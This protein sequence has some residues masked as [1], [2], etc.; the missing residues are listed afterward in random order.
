M[1]FKAPGAGR[2][3]SPGGPPVNVQARA[4]CLSPCSPRGDR[5]ADYSRKSGACAITPIPTEAKDGWELVRGLHA[6]LVLNS[7][8]LSVC[9]PFMYPEFRVEAV[10]LRSLGGPCF[11]AELGIICD[12]LLGRINQSPLSGCQDPAWAVP[13]Y[14]LFISKCTR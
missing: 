3:V 6:G 13:A 4:T 12:W 14:L 8:I 1:G 9:A 5:A 2:A 11:I 7:I 10:R